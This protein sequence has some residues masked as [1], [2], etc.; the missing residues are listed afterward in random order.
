[1]FWY[2]KKTKHSY[3][4]VR[5][6]PNYLL[7]EEQPSTYKFYPKEYKRVEDNFIYGIAGISAE[8]KIPSGSYFLRINPSAGAL[9]PN[10]L[11]LQIR[12][13]EGLEDGIYHYEV[14]TDRLT[15]LKAISKDEGLEPFFNLKNQVKGYL[16]LVSTP[17]YR[18]CWKYRD[19]AFRYSLLDAGHILGSIEINSFL[20]KEST[21]VYFNIQKE[22]LNK[23]FNFNNEEFFLAGA[24]IGTTLDY[25]VKKVELDLPYINASGDFEKNEMVEK[26]YNETKVWHKNCKDE[27]REPKFDYELKRVQKTILQR[28]SE[29]A[30]YK[31]AITKEQFD[32]ILKQINE[33]LLS[34]CDTNIN[35]YLVAHRVKDLP[36]G[37]YKDG[38]IIKKGDFMKKSG[39]LCLEQYNLGSNGAVTFFLTS[40]DEN[41][42]A[43]YQKAGIIG[44]RL[45]IASLYLGIGCSGIGAYY[46]DEVNEFLGNNEMVLYA[47]AIGK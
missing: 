46:D 16:F 23:L 30:F 5:M 3:K 9:Y 24:L 38:E 20:K 12:E 13:V 14:K 21:K 29:R 17:Y 47:L 43:L 15:L 22:E 35:I 8:K 34:D 33:P 19:R 7:W 28:R 18:S 32:F 6:N 37:I 42:Q 27:N 2:H 4:S 41:Y 11:Y 31:N 39:Y 40:K 36:L 1:M 25:E 10:E 45:Y 44:H 26:V